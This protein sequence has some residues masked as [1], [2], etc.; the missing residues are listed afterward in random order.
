MRRD[1]DLAIATAIF[2]AAYVVLIWLME[3]AR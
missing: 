3:A 2:L 1:F